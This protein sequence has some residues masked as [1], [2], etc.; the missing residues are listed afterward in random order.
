MEERVRSVSQGRQIAYDLTYMWNLKKTNSETEQ[1]DSCQ[2]QIRGTGLG[3]EGLGRRVSEKNRKE[4]E[5]KVGS[6]S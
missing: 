5:K 4:S 3:L 6:I 1:I 2:R